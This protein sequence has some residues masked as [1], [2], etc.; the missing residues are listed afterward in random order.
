MLKYSRMDKAVVYNAGMFTP[1]EFHH[2][3]IHQNST[4]WK[5]YVVCVYTEKR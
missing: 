5:C 4:V 1:I 2:V 3:E